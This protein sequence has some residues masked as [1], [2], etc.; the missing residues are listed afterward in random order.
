MNNV[1]PPLG[2]H[3]TLEADMGRE[4]SDSWQLLS[5]TESH[6]NEMDLKAVQV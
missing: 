5:K 3:V 1:T 6:R 2:G 4:W